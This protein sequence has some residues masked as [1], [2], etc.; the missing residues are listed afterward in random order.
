MNKK[1]TKTSDLITLLLFKDNRSPRTLQF[2][3]RWFH[4]LSI[5]IGFFVITAIV[6]TVLA[7][8]YFQKLRNS[9]PTHLQD[10]EQEIGRLKEA[11]R[12]LESKESVV[13][14]AA[15]TP[16][17]FPIQS[18]ESE[19]SSPPAAP[20]KPAEN[21]SGAPYLFSG[22]PQQQTPKAAPSQ[23]ELSISL[24]APKIY[25][26]AQTLIANFAL[27]YTKEDKGNQQG[28]IIV[29]AR[30]EETLLGYPESLFQ[31]A[32]QASLID[33]SKGEYFSVSRF[34]EVSA[35][36][37]SVSS[38]KLLKTVEIIILNSAGEILIHQIHPIPQ[39][40]ASHS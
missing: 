6:S 33:P 40:E 3:E 7:L 39:D 34:R 27:Q 31:A 12:H 9:D 35:E 20:G 4:K 19:N 36:F 14:S 18:S 30:G 38:R 24:T 2:S 26:K 22:L 5:L 15:P 32:G 21:I 11:N 37:D 8:T 16:S 1:A 28:K 17:A 25:W 23:T 10:L 13:Q 29:L